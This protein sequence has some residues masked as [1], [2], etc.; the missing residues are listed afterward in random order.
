MVISIAAARMGEAGW[1]NDEAVL[2]WHLAGE[3]HL[4]S[5]SKIINGLTVAATPKVLAMFIT[6]INSS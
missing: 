6:R 2:A 3:H 4:S 1:G 5:V